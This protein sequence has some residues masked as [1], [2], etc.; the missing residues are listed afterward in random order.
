MCFEAMDRV[1]TTK[2]VVSWGNVIGLSQYFSPIGRSPAVVLKE[3]N[4]SGSLTT[5]EISGET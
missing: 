5:H 3:L 1:I 2:W 4:E